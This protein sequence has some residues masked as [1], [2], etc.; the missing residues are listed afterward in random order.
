MQKG[1]F[2]MSLQELNYVIKE[3][4]RAAYPKVEN[5]KPNHQF[6]RLVYEAYAGSKSELTTI[7]SYVFQYLTNEEAQDVV[8]LL[9]AISKQEMKHLELLGEML[10][11][12]GLEPYYMSTYGNKWC[13]DNVKSSFNGL[14]EMLDYNIESEKGAIEGYKHLIESC[15]CNHLKMIFARIIMD[16]ENHIK[17]FEMLKRKY[18]DCED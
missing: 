5:I 2:F 1:G 3:M 18:C 9:K 14:M 10:V 16:E 17:I 12:L 8:L 6:G 15:E 13:S 7:L 11:G 4:N